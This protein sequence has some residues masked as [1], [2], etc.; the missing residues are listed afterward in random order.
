MKRKIGYNRREWLNDEKSAST[1]NVVA[2]DGIIHWDGRP[3]RRTFLQVSDCNNSIRLHVTE[4]D[5]EQDF[6][7]K[8]I[9]L[10]D[11]IDDFIQ[12]LKNE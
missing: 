2:F 3:I 5:T 12:Y 1:G 11:V 10:R 9:K 6:I 7:N 4:D 8:M